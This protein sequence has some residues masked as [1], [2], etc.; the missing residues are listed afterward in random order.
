[1]L[2]A[3]H[4]TEAE[5]FSRRIRGMVQD[6]GTTLGISLSEDTQAA[7]RWALYSEHRPGELHL[8]AHRS[9]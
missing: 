3:S 8:H 4:T 9:I 7:G 6:H 5:R 2:G 1:M